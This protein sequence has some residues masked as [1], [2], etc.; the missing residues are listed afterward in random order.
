MFG[1]FKGDKI[2]G[3]KTNLSKEEKLV[4][5]MNR[6]TIIVGNWNYLHTELRYI[7]RK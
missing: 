2:M 4:N 6:V 5:L 1:S 3:S 7:Q